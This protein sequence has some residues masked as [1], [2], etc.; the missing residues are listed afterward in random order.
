MKTTKIGIILLALL[1]VS[2]GIVP[3]V[4]AAGTMDNVDADTAMNVAS[5]HV[6]ELSL[7]SQEYSDWTDASLERSTTFFDLKGDKT[8]YSFNVMADGKKSGYYTRFGKIVQLPYPGILSWTVAGHNPG[9][10]DG[11]RKDCP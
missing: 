5:R 10:N 9:V 8:A 3:F 7:S 1:L 4:S 11:F 2:M 6:Q